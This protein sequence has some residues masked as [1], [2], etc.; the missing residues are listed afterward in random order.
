MSFWISSFGLILLKML[1]GKRKIN[2]RKPP[3]KTLA[4]TIFIVLAIVLKQIRKKWISRFRNPQKLV[5]LGCHKCWSSNC[6]RLK[7]FS[8]GIVACA[9]LKNC[10]WSKNSCSVCLKRNHGFRGN[11][12]CV[13]RLHFGQASRKTILELIVRRVTGFWKGGGGGGRLWFL[14][15]KK[16]LQGLNCFCSPRGAL[17]SA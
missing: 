8:S 11:Q 12:S 15:H 7:H 16:S 1:W 5:S 3:K 6:R 2:I 9:R 13:E 10:L 14:E 4:P 17:E